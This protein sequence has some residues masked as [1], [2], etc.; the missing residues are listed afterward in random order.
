MRKPD[1]PKVMRLRTWL[2]KL[3]DIPEPVEVE[4][5]YRGA[6]RHYAKSMIERNYFTKGGIY[7]AVEW[8]RL[9]R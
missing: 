8:A 7:L 9:K 2:V 6:A 4:A 5:E 1:R 3:R